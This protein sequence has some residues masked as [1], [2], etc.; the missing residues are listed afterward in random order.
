MKGL[1]V[2]RSAIVVVAAL[3]SAGV[4]SLA[5]AQ[6]KIGVVDVQRLVR[7]SPQGK[8][9]NEALDAEFGP[10]YKEIQQRA[11]SL[12]AKQ[13][14]LRKDEATMTEVQKAQVE[15]ELRDGYRELQLRESTF[16]DDHNAARQE[17]QDKLQRVL[18][19]EVKAF[20]KAQ[21][22][23]LILTD[24]AFV[25]PALDVTGAILDALKARKTAA[26]AAAPAATTPQA[27]KPPAP[28]AAIARP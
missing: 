16:T 6:T 18:D 17:Q 1:I 12:Q 7:E 28:P 13:D 3:L 4:A 24:A 15:K 8:A 22:Y 11:Q 20:A 25:T 26:P 10:K 2:K 21:G 14:K 5:S 9:A 27:S 23:D 19:E